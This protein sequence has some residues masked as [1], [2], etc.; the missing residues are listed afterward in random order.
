MSGLDHTGSGVIGSKADFQT[1]LKKT[2][3]SKKVYAEPHW[4]QKCIRPALSFST[5]ADSSSALLK[6]VQMN[7]KI[8]CEVHQSLDRAQ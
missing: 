6:R 3:E 8:N 1:L 4:S 7:L 2:A 5:S